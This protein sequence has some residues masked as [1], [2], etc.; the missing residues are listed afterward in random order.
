M[1]GNAF[2]LSRIAFLASDKHTGFPYGLAVDIDFDPAKDAQNIAKH[3]VSLSFAAVVLA[4]AIGAVG[5]SRHAYR[6]TRIK[7]FA[8]IDGVFFGC[9]TRCGTTLLGSSACVASERGRFA[10]G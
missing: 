6:E 1:S 3:G 4:D 8:Q 10:D 9:S 5:D 7:A 2:D